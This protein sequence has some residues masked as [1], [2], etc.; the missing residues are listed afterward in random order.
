MNKRDLRVEADR[1]NPG[2]VGE[3][4]RAADEGQ[5]ADR[6]AELRQ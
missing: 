3:A 6:P 2:R 5:R 1:R 4:G